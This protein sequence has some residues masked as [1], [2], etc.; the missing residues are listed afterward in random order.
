MTTK[1][2]YEEIAA[3]L[4]EKI[5]QG[6]LP[7]G[8]RLPS[9]RD[10]TEGYGVQRNT[11]RQALTLLEKEGWLQVRP[12]SGAFAALAATNG[13][14]HPSPSTPVA[15]GNIL[16]INAWNRSSTALDRILSGLSR[17]LTN[18]QFGIQRFNSQPAEG[19]RLHVLPS[20]DYLRSNRVVGA[21]LW[22]QNPTDFAALAEIRDVLPLILVDRHVV[23]FE[24]DCVRF[25]DRAGGQLIT[26]HLL[27]RGHRRIGFL[28]DEV[29]AETVQQRWHGY[30]LALEQAGIPPDPALFAFFEGIKE[31]NFTE[32]MRI[33]LAGAGDPLSAVVC[34]ND[35]TA[36]TLLRFLR[37]AGIRV[38]EDVAVT[39]YG[40]LLADY[41]DTIDLTTVEQPFE[42][43]GRTAGELLRERLA[44]G[45]PFAPG[46]FRQIE[47]PVHLIARNSSSARVPALV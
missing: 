11:V 44:S 18:T 25:D 10:L 5:R 19:T 35:S 30:A 3:D 42:E 2:R 46:K 17:S 13:D 9:E 24:T 47:L 4:R 22:A 40:N 41:M 20:T 29:F 34:S 6:H 33:F 15:E 39:G 14:G 38:P 43:V 45:T 28:G 23:G 32:Y 21:I 36:L 31:P 1:F 7:V 37:G 8:R 12:R 26:E 27:A 16:V